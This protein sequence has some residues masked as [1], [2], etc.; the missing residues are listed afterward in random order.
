[1]PQVDYNNLSIL[2]A[3]VG[4]LGYVIKQIVPALMKEIREKNAYIELI[5]NKF[6]EATNHK[7]TELTNALN[8]LTA[9]NKETLAIL[10]QQSKRHSKCK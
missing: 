4:L 3:I 9:I 1:M 2:I 7:T 6:L 5:T 8:E 10:K